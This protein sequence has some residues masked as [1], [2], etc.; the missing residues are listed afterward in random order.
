MN[1]LPQNPKLLENTS[2][3][4]E[5]FKEEMRQMEEFRKNLREKLV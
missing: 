3:W 1:D 2:A 5:S 4:S